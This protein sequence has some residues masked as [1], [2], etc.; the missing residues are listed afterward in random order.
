VL[1]LPRCEVLPIEVMA[2]CEHFAAQGGVVIT[3]DGLPH[4]A[5]PQ[6]DDQQLRNMVQ[7][8]QAKQQFIELTMADLEPVFTAI[9]QAVPDVV[10]ITQGTSTTVNN[11]PCYEPFLIDPYLHNGEDLTGIQFSRYIKDGWRNT[12]FMNYSANPETIR[13]KVQTPEA[14]EIW[15]TFTGEIK[16]PTII[17]QNLDTCEV[18]ISLPCN[19][20]VILVSKLKKV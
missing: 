2:L 18:E 11:H 14:P 1:V 3:L 16:R 4:Y 13:V 5:M 6:R 17:S 19:Y 9:R 12:F 7:A 20:G 10:T 8:M 15:D